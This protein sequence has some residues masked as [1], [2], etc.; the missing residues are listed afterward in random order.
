MKNFLNKVS[1]IWGFKK[2]E[3][4]KALRS[5]E[6]KQVY[7]IATNEGKF[8]ITGFGSHRSEMSFQQYISALE[9]V[10]N[11]PF[12]LTPTILK[13]KENSSYTKVSDRFICITEY[14]D[15]RSLKQVPEDEY[16]LGQTTALLNSLDDYKINSSIKINNVIERAYE[17]L[18]KCPFNKEYYKLID[19]LPNFNNYKQ[20]FIHTDIAPHN[21]ILSKEDKVV[22]IDFDSS[23]NGSIYVDAGFPL[24]MHFVRFVG[25]GE[26]RFNSENAQAFYKGYS[27]ITEL[28]T[29]DKQ[30]MYEGAIFRQ[31]MHMAHYEPDTKNPTFEILK[32]AVDHKDELISVL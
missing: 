22:L 19:S 1:E 26:L 4:I 18:S 30:L 5:G 20:G 21:A 13:N 8:I 24:I 6:S 14:I 10:E 3:L 31:L 7:L 28:N 9:Y 29:V 16:R 15:G 25:P 2:I 32:F 17:K 27:S 23:G 11:K 12:K